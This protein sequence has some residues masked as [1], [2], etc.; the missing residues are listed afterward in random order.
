MVDLR[1]RGGQPRRERGA[2][3]V[4][5]AIILPV[6]LT[7][8]FGIIDYGLFFF[9]SIGL[10]Q[11]ARE[12]ARQAVV[13]RVD[14]A[15][16]GTTV[17]YEAIACTARFNSNNVLGRTAGATSGAGPAQVKVKMSIAMSAPNTTA[18]WK[19]G[20]QLMVCTQVSERAATGLVPFPGNGIMT[21]KVVM[22]IEKDSS[23]PSGTL[24]SDAA[25]SGGNWTWC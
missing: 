12:A 11:G 8:I 21:S 25:P 24:V 22:S 4:E 17:S 13:L 1:R 9:D 19:Q 14:T 7:L 3:A 10:R 6:L 20:N 2:S 15:A 18:T 16:C 23:V 5:F